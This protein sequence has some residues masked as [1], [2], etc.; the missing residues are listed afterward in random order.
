MKIFYLN[1]LIKKL[2]GVLKKILILILII[3]VIGIFWGYNQRR[4]MVFIDNGNT[5]AAANQGLELPMPIPSQVSTEKEGIRI[6]LE[7]VVAEKYFII[8]SKIY[9]DQSHFGI[10]LLITD[11]QKRPL[12]KGKFKV[13]IKNKEGHYYKPLLEPE[14]VDFPPDQPL[15]WKLTSFV[16][17]PYR[18]ALEKEIQIFISYKGINFVLPPVKLWGK[19]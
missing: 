12:G 16:I 18:V 14:L 9:G 4:E 6:D 15:G 3:F 17:F 1:E 11:L 13:S 8:Y 7:K 5:M 19:G 10:N 2:L